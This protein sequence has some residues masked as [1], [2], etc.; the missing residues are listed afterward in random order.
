MTY[1]T[2]AAEESA[3]A[4]KQRNIQIR[5]QYK[6][7][8]VE[9]MQ[10]IYATLDDSTHSTD[11]K[12]FEHLLRLCQS[13]DRLHWQV[14]ECKKKI[15]SYNP[16]YFGNH[17]HT[18]PNSST[19]QESATSNLD[20]LD[21]L[22]EQAEEEQ[23]T[24]DQ[25]GASIQPESQESVPAELSAASDYDSMRGPTA[26]ATRSEPEAHNEYLES[27]RTSGSTEC[28]V[29]QLNELIQEFQ[30]HKDYTL[31]RERYMQLSVEL[32]LQKCL[33]PAGRE[34]PAI[35]SGKPRGDQFHIDVFVDQIVI[36][37]H[38]LHT[39]QHPIDFQR[40]DVRY[41]E[42]FNAQHPFDFDL[43]RDFAQQNWSRNHRAVETMFLPPHLQ[44]QL[45]ALRSKELQEAYKALQTKRKGLDTQ[46][47]LATFKQE[48][49][50]W[51]HRD[52]RVKDAATYQTLWEVHMVLGS[53]TTPK[54]LAELTALL[55]GKP[56]LTGK[57]VAEKLKKLQKHTSPSIWA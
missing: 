10:K 56:L 45:A 17:V 18:E 5:N 8:P 57:T 36:D 50:L 3:Y 54:M 30:R 16:L 24:S 1:T 53:S 51:Q 13:A 46:S 25:E 11:E 52:P 22:L 43:A 48:F 44:M 42:I 6:H 32:N 28:V 4:F 40:N 38:W 39:N 26:H 41:K 37:C 2:T 27:V 31:V 23:V 35:S 33:A 7:L 20:D 29:S 55:T 21:Y 19:P 9:A 12:F 34:N 14:M 15:A 47:R 49:R